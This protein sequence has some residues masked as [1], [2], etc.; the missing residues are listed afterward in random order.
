MKTSSYRERDNE[1]H[2]MHEENSHDDATAKLRS[3]ATK[4]KGRGFSSVDD[5]GT[6]MDV[7]HEFDQLD[8]EN[9]VEHAQ[10]CWIIFV[11]GLHEEITEEDI[12]DKFADF[13]EI[14]NL[15]LNLDRRTGFVKGYALIEYRDFKEAEA[16]VSNMNGAL[17]FDRPVKCDFAFVHE[18]R[19]RRSDNRRK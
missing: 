10:K 19:D 4:R 3:A 15:H 8:P 12:Q 17:I 7:D 11:T 1:R 14:M 6:A 2:E 9:A 5:K 16:A 18:R 13:G